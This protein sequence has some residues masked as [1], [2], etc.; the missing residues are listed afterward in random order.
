MG[1]G[2]EQAAVALEANQMD[3]GR[4]VLMLLEQSRL[5]ANVSAAREL[6][7]GSRGWGG[8]GGKGGGGD[9]GGDGGGTAAAP[10]MRPRRRAANISSWT[11]AAAAGA[12]GEEQMMLKASALDGH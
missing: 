9:G 3:V 4:A 7:R 10:P 1:F 12:S 6:V 11:T 5:H 8:A 2:A